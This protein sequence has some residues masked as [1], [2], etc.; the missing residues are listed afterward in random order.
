[1]D[2]T[3]FF[4]GE[5]HAPGLEDDKDGYGRY[6]LDADG[7][8]KAPYTRATTV[9][10]MLD[11]GK[12]L[13]IWQQRKVA[14]GVAQSPA[15]VA[16]AA[17]TPLDD[18]QAWREILDQAEVKSGG[19]EKRDLG[20]A[21][22]ALHEHV[23]TMSDSEWAA[24]PADLKCTYVKY[25]AEL[26]RLGITEI[27]TEVTLVNTKI[28]TAGKADAIFQLADGRLVIGDRKS[29]RI[30]EYPHSAAVQFAI[31]A[32]ADVLLT[33][34]EDGSVERHPMPELD[35]TT[36]IVIDV[37]IGDETTASVH[38]YEVD[39]WAGWAAALLSA[40]IRR[41]RNR[42]DLLTPYHPEFPPTDKARNAA[43]VEITQHPEAWAKAPVKVAGFTTAAQV[44]ATAY[45]DNVPGMKRVVTDDSGVDWVVPEE[46]T[47]AEIGANVGTDAAKTLRTVP[48]T[49]PG[50]VFTDGT[51]GGYHA[52]PEERADFAAELPPPS[53]GFPTEVAHGPAA[54]AS[55]GMSPTAKAVLGTG[56]PIGT[57]GVPGSTHPAWSSKEQA[58][59]H[60]D[61]KGER[62][63]NPSS[64]ADAAGEQADAKAGDVDALLATFKTKAQL[65][66][67]ARR[68]DPGIKVERTKANLAND[69]V[70][71]PNWRH[72]RAQLI[73]I[74]AETPPI[75]PVGVDDTSFSETVSNAP[76]PVPPDP[77][78][79]YAAT[80]QTDSEAFTN[81]QNTGDPYVQGPPRPAADNGMSVSDD[82]AAYI[83][84]NPFVQP[85]PEPA[86][87]QAAPPLA[88]SVEDQVLQQIGEAAT[89]D[90]L[91]AAW[92][93]ANDAGIGWPPRLHKAA[94]IRQNQLTQ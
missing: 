1:M 15:L 27:M 31:Y 61:S 3:E 12:G 81:A 75:E 65:Q 6:L 60:L 28:G 47:L 22:H 26:K 48:I 35:L 58:V 14:K 42:R 9:A 50:S 5:P 21:F 89:L 25:R 41:W 19:D 10:K 72:V 87:F 37:K 73:P 13:E 51:S 84:A 32:N 54:N 76:G 52:T 7:K 46:A 83:S 33:W 80:G 74:T 67:A 36:A 93:T 68:V 20:S 94:T 63:P 8:G 59:I 2:S 11:S 66:A 77:E 91:A 88:L 44:N 16:R 71:H 43:T 23:E 24:V 78:P 45:G 85:T 49:A 92:Q 40:K 53:T 39:I 17:V 64:L 69:M 56:A 55:A 79:G 29:G 34:N 57:S 86:P 30:T 4:G 70:S 62:V 82:E 38:A 90:D 18:K